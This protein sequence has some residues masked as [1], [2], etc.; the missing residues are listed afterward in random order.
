MS[1]KERNKNKKE[2]KT[3]E[4]PSSLFQRQRVD[5]LLGELMK[6]FAFPL[7]PQVMQIQQQQQQNATK[8][9]NSESENQTEANETANMN[10][11]SESGQDP[12]SD[13]KPPPEKKMKL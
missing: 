2:D 13:M 9:S 5:M 10:G 8:T 12:K 1:E 3:K 11:N 7:I 4:E 6:K